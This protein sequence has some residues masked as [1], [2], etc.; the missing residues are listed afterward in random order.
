M[1]RSTS[2]WQD[3]VCNTMKAIMHLRHVSL[4][5]VGGGG[6]MGAERQAGWWSSETS[7]AGARFFYFLF[8]FPLLV[9]LRK[10]LETGMSRI[11][12]D[13]V[14]LQLIFGKS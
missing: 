9:Q 13:G 5:S 12:A 3:E 4:G 7:S 10:R 14:N 11:N 8:F 6:E 1:C 2:V